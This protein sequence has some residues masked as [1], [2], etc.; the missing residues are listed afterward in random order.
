MNSLFLI[1]IGK[2]DDESTLTVLEKPGTHVQQFTVHLRVRFPIFT[3][4]K[5]HGFPNFHIYWLHQLN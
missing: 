4:P 1:L 5:L 2:A 3:M